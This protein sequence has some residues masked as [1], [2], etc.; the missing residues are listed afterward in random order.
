MQLLYLAHSESRLNLLEVM[1]AIRTITELRYVYPYHPRKAVAVRGTPAQIELMEWM[2]AQLDPRAGA[3]P[4]PNSYD[5]PDGTAD[6]VRVRH[7]VH[8]G[9]PQKLQE[10]MTLIRT[11]T[12]IRRVFPVQSRS[13]ISWRGTADQIRL[14]EWLTRELDQP[15]DAPLPLNTTEHQTAAN[16]GSGELVRLFF[17]A[18]AGAPRDLGEAMTLMRVLTEMRRA[19]PCQARSALGFRGT[20]EQM[21]LGEW[22][23]KMLEKPPGSAPQMT[24]A[25]NEQVGVFYLA[26]ARTSQELWALFTAVRTATQASPISFTE[27]QKAIAIRGTADQVATAKRMIEQP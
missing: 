25:G 24:A 12:D 9:T 19:F 15:D 13:A 18:Q 3:P 17:L 20:P 4:T 23:V 6:V 16:D 14:V 2:A 5:V 8:S 26:P 1:T 21:R 27:A 10:V 7:L 11:M 22:L